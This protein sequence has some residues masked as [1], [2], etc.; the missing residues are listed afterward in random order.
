MSYSIDS[1]KTNDVSAASINILYPSGYTSG[2]H[3]LR[4]KGFAGT[5]YCETDIPISITGGIAASSGASLYTSS[6]SQYPYSG[7]ES[8]PDYTGTYSPCPA[9]SPGPGNDGANESPYIGLWQTQPDCQTPGT[10]TNV[11]TAF[12]VSTPVHGLNSSSRQFTFGYGPQN[13]SGVRWFNALP[14]NHSSGS[15]DAATHFLYDIYVYFASG[16]NV[17]AIEL[18]INHASPANNL[19]LLGVQCYLGDGHWQVT[20][21]NVW[22]DTDNLCISG[23]VPTGSWHH[24]Q[25]LTSHDASPGQN[26]SYEQVAMDGA[27]QSLTCKA[28]A[29][30][31]VAQSVPWAQ[32]VGPNFQLDG[33]ASAGGSVVAYVSNFNIWYW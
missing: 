9:N 28:K 8:F 30:E 29:C 2:S 5:K 24:F 26:I 32:S 10:K 17:S 7:I 27:V 16:S 11:S 3:I 15:P 25:V 21:N 33:D 20:V 19:Y 22:V 14:D 23:S 31:S 4:V 1:D 13:A 12:P 18:D 6:L